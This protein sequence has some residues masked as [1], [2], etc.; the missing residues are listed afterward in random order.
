MQFPEQLSLILDC[1]PFAN[2]TYGVEANLS[3]IQWFRIA[4]IPPERVGAE[5]EITDN[6]TMNI[7]LTKNKERL[8]IRKLTI[9]TGAQVGTEA[10]YRCRVCRNEPPEPQSCANATTV[11][12][13]NSE[14]HAHLTC[15]QYIVQ[16]A[17]SM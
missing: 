13:A 16:H 17:Y 3:S 1:L 2:N 12:S 5:A 8:F 11:I 15:M 14:C 7:F 10:A 4:S 6:S 9:A